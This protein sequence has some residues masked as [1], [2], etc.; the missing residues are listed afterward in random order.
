MTRFLDARL[1]ETPEVL[2]ADVR[3]VGAGAAGM[4]LALQLAGAG[5]EVL[6]LESGGEQIDAETQGL[7]AAEMAGLNYVDLS[8]GRLRFLGGTTNHW[9]GNCRENDPIDYGGRADMGVPG[10]PVGYHDI[11]PYVVRAAQSLGLGMLGFEPEPVAKKAGYGAEALVDRKSDALQTKVFQF[12]GRTR[13][14][15][16]YAGDLQRAPTLKPVLHANV[17]HIQLDEAGRTVTHLVVRTLSQRQLTVRARTFVIAAHAIE[18]ARLLLSSNDVQAAGVGNGSGHV[19]RYFMEHPVIEAGVMYPTAKFCR[20]YDAGATRS[21][22][23]VVDV[24][25]TAAAM[26]SQRMLSYYCRFHPVVASNETLAAIDTVKA[27]FWRPADLAA[28]Q[29]MGTMLAD[30]PGVIRYIDDRK[31]SKGWIAPKAY[32]LKHRIEQAPNAS[33]RVTLSAQRD[34]IGSPKARLEWNLSPLDYRSFVKGQSLVEREFTRLGLGTFQ[35][36]ALTPEMV[37][38]SV[39]GTNHHI[40]TT[41]M[42]DSPGDGVVDR[43]GKVHGVENLYIAGSSIFP[44]AGYSGPTM[45]LIAFAIRLADHLTHQ[46]R[47]K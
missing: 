40:G 10:W 14:R 15:E 21:L 47:A 7:C 11:R 41:R 23:M 3:I 37:N 45:M 32:R 44:T 26:Q 13:F 39:Q 24:S 46:R 17:T 29:A 9:A 33:S 28:I 16:L 36:A 20:L 27:G 42:A 25:P 6:L 12:A 38:A 8:A 2:I 30:I 5:I 4:T 19:G 22:G 34:R 18:N 43:H 1:G 35:M 31:L